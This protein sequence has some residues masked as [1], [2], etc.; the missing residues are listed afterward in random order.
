MRQEDQ[1]QQLRTFFNLL[2]S[3]NVSALNQL[4]ALTETLREML[5]GFVEKHAE[6]R[7]RL[8]DARNVGK[9]STD[10]ATPL[11]EHRAVDLLLDLLSR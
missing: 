4:E 6:V 1:I 8:T 2:E 9:S 10:G 5:P 11:P 3:G 7:G